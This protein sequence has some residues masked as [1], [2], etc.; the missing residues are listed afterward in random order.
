MNSS[1][2]WFII[3]IITIIDN[4]RCQIISIQMIKFT[5]KIINTMN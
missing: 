1:L 5:N 2:K 4:Q 3:E